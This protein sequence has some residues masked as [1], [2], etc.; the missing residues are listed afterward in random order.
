MAFSEICCHV[1]SSNYCFD[2]GIFINKSTT[3]FYRYSNFIVSS[4]A[5]FCVCD[6]VLWQ[7]KHGVW[8]FLVR[9]WQFYFYWHGNFIIFHTIMAIFSFLLACHFY[10]F[11]HGN[12]LYVILLIWQSKILIFEHG[13]F[14]NKGTTFFYC[15]DIFIVSSMSFF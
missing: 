2:H 3:F 4:M 6:F 10:C 13:H 9:T 7:G 5:I 11:D 12:F 1:T 8:L 15:H 14:I